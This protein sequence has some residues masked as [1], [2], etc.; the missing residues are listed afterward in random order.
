[1]ITLASVGVCSC[2]STLIAGVALAGS[3][4]LVDPQHGD[5][6]AVIGG[7]RTEPG[8]F[9]EV[10]AI[11]TDTSLC[12]GT[13]VAADLVL[14]AGHCLDGLEAGDDVTVYF[15]DELAPEGSVAAAD[16]EVHPEFCRACKEDIFDYGFVVLS[17]AVEA[18]I[19]SA[20][21]TQAQWD[22]VISIGTA[23]T[24]VGFG[25]DPNAPSVESAGIKRK[26]DVEISAI[27]SDGQ[28]FFAGGDQHDA[29]DGDG[30][31]PAFV[32]LAD[33]TRLLAG[34]VSRGSARCGSGGSY[35]ASAPAA[36]WILDRTGVDLTA[37]CASC[38]C[39]D[40]TPSGGGEQG[41][42]ETGTSGGPGTLDDGAPADG[43]G[44]A[45]G[46]CGC[47]GGSAPPWLAWLALIPLVQRTRR[48]SDRS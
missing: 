17:T 8:E 47:R 32:T 31:A 28:E 4:E 42:S 18:P 36:C 26:T 14:T 9:A 30:G 16:Y 41:E 39:V 48:R 46:G 2:F 7:E 44:M 19:A 5:G 40:I 21:T 1:M 37:G 12:S 20:I 45:I 43:A 10:V 29:C 3:G 15:G 35:G 27:S 24:V 11:V 13:L 23:A 34:V 38:N 25:E 22:E 33:G 6:V